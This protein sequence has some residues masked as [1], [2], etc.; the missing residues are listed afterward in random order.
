MA[1]TAIQI[2]STEYGSNSQALVNNSELDV[3]KSGR[4]G[5]VVPPSQT[6]STPNVQYETTLASPVGRITSGSNSGEQYMISAA[7]KVP[8][9]GARKIAAI[10]AP[11]PAA[12]KT[13]RSAG[14][15]RRNPPSN[16]PNPAPICAIGPSRPP[17][18]PEP[19]VSALATSLMSGTRGR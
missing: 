14:R 7:N 15:N 16:D 17:D 2:A 19:I 6:A 13:R 3:V 4:Q 10:P 1:S 8:A 5:V 9:S 11:I 18:P 12:S